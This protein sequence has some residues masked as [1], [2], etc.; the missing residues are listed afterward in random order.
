[1]HKN[2]RETKGKGGTIVSV[3]QIRHHYITD[4]MDDVQTHTGKTRT[5]DISVS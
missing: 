2:K 4:K 3:V 5:A 1:M